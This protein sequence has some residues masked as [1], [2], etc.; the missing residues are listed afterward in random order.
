MATPKF[1]SREHV[2]REYVAALVQVHITPCRV[3]QL[4]NIVPNEATVMFTPQ[5]K[6][7]CSGY[8]FSPFMFFLICCYD[9][10]KI[11]CLILLIRCCSYSWF[12]AKH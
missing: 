7:P 5:H 8:L 11:L 12:S 3:E 6:F 9:Y 10:F 1:A 2:G 4:Q